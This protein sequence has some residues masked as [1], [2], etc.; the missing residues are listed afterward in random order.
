MLRAE[1]LACFPEHAA[2]FGPR[3]QYLGSEVFISLVDQREAPFSD[4]LKQLSVRTLCTNRDLPLLM[5]G[6]SSEGDFTTVESVP[7]DRVRTVAG[8]T[9]PTSSVA[10]NEIT[11][12]LISHLSLNYLA[13]T[14]LSEEEGAATLRDL[15]RLYLDLGDKDLSGQV[16]SIKGVGISA[17][18]RR[19]PQHGQLVY[20]RGVGVSVGVD[21]SSL[22]GVSPWPLMAVLERFFARHVGVNSYTELALDSRQRGRI[23][24]WR[25]RPGQRPCT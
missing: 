1:S 5:G 13:M 20:G 3:T 2:R 16:S 23:A 14:D 11:W 4:D 9:R 18:T 25:V 24:Q 17:I 12:R 15:L 22:A 6:R 21:E 7:V 10:E 8:P 19:L